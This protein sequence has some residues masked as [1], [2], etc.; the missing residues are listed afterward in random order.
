MKIGI[1]VYSQTGNTLSVAEKLK[2][3]LAAKGHAVSIERIA[4]MGGIPKDKKDIRFEKLPDLTKF[5][6]LVLAAPVQAFSLNPVMAA[7]LPLLPSLSGKK[8]ACFATKQFANDWTGGSKAIA[9]MTKAIE[10]QNGKVCGSGIVG[11]K[12]K[13]REKDIDELVEKLSCLF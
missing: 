4:T 13:Q 1:V 5:D 7:Y 2:D 10:G 8:I 12:S 9:M 11:W 6:A 3:L